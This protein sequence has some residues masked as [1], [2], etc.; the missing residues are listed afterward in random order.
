MPVDHS[1][2]ERGFRRPA[3]VVGAVGHAEQFHHD[4]L[5]E[6]GNLVFAEE[7]PLRSRSYCFVRKAGGDGN[8]RMTPD[9]ARRAV[10]VLLHP[11]APATVAFFGGEPLLEWDVIT[12]TVEAVKHLR[13]G[14]RTPQFHITTNGAL[15]DTRKVAYLD[16]EGFTMI[17]SLDGPKPIHDA[18]RRGA[19]GEGSYD[20]TLRGLKLLRGRRLAAR[21]TLRATFQPT[22][23]RLC[24]RLGHHLQLLDQGLCRHVTIE[25]VSPTEDTHEGVP[26][27]FASP[28]VAWD[29]VDAEHGDAARL[30]RD[31]VRQGR[32]ASFEQLVG[33]VRRLALRQA[34]SSGCNAGNGY[35]SVGPDEALRAK[36]L[37]NRFYLSAK[38]LQC[39][40]YFSDLVALIDG[41]EGVSHVVMRRPTRD[42]SIKAGELAVGGT[43][44]ITALYVTE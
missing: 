17:V 18:S 8:A 9:V 35:V 5:F 28:A 38:C 22:G 44:N 32:P 41:V 31:R 40:I 21:T 24:E 37:D 16:R 26:G 15:L 4:G 12:Q 10:E 1:S 20:D 42:I 27:S 6:V 14:P 7:E 39:P 33:F 43:T 29:V 34:A 30:L 11:Q 3:S 13:R 25:P 36:W 19:R 2:D 23:M